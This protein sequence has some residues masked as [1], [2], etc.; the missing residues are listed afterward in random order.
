MY[1]I[2][3]K[4]HHTKRGNNHLTENGLLILQ[5]FVFLERQ[6]AVEAAADEIR[7]R[8]L[9]DLVLEED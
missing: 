3:S 9:L 5:G 4:R 2:A 1:E 8:F 7:Q 6:E